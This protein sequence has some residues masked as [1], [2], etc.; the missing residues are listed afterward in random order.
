[1]EEHRCRNCKKKLPARETGARGRHRRYC[2]PACRSLHYQE[3]F[4]RAVAMASIDAK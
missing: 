2:N 4:R 1:M 3:M